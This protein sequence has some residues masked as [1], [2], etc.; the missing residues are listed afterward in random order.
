MNSSFFVFD[1]VAGEAGLEIKSDTRNLIYQKRD[2]PKKAV[3]LILRE[4]SQ[5]GS[6]GDCFAEFNGAH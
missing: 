1:L 2:D 5:S 3:G 4:E 6:G